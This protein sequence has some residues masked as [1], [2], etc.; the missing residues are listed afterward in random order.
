[1]CKIGD[2]IGVPIIEGQFI[3]ALKEVRDSQKLLAIPSVHNKWK[4]NI[5]FFFLI[6]LVKSNW[7]IK[8]KVTIYNHTRIS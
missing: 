2:I 6:K 8:N 4:R 7:N 5:S 3:K 1:M